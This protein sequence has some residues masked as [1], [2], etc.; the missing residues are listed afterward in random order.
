MFEPVAAE[1]YPGN[2]V[3]IAQVVNG[4]EPVADAEV[5]IFAGEECREAA[6]T[7][8]RG[9]IY[10]TV[11]GNEPTQLHFIIVTDGQWLMVNGQSITYETDAVCGTPRAPFV[12][13]LGNATAI[14]GV[15]LSTVNSQLSTVYD[16]QGRRVNSQMMQSSNRQTKGV[17]IMDGQKIVK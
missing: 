2:M 11:P 8:D 10:V 16:L 14:D 15:Q 17:Y 3:V 6:V 7:D 5:G 9:M 13:D 1:S 4:S 12:I